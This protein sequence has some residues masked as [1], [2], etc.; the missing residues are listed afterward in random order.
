[1]DELKDRA[2]QVLAGNRFLVLGTIDDDGRPRVSPV[3]F[4]HADHHAFYWVS[5]P[6][7]HHS[8][9]IAARPRVSFVVFD[10][11]VTP[12]EQ[13]QAAVYVDA[14][15]VEVPE[16]ELAAE[17]ARA[18]AHLRG[19]GARAFAPEEVSGDAGIRLY[20]AVATRHEVHVRGGD[21]TYGKGVD[22][23]VTVEL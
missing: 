13:A 16:A 11:S 1:M 10:S 18:F 23:R 15:A 8:R 3:Y 4:T 12:A 20:R 7:S 22:A 5:S 19:D 6:E 17:C 2:I 9:N 21:P 14:D